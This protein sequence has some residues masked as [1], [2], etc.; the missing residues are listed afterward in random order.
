[1]NKDEL[2]L[3]A[4]RSLKLCADYSKTITTGNV[5]HVRPALEGS[6]RRNAEYLEKYYKILIEDETRD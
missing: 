6:L 3:F 4:I 2:I 1:M 5:A